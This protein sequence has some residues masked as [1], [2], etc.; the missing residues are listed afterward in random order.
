MHILSKY[1]GSTVRTL[2]SIGISE[3]FSIL[4]RN[5]SSPWK[6]EIAG[7]GWDKSLFF[8]CN[9]NNQ[10]QR[11]LSTYR[12]SYTCFPNYFI[13]F[14][15]V[16][17]GVELVFYCPLAAGAPNYWNCLNMLLNWSCG[18]TRRQRLV[19]AQHVKRRIKLNLSPDGYKFNSFYRGHVKV[20][21][22]VENW[23]SW[24]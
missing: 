3:L 22:K 23:K 18:A 13:H 1:R 17:Q 4:T 6:W 5:V 7:R 9:R 12:L 21:I 19:T 14:S 24:W 11:F 2:T 20:M 16:Q 10:H 15:P 8:I